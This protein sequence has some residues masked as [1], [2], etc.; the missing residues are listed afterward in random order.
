MLTY[1]PILLYDVNTLIVLRGSTIKKLLFVN[2]L[3]I[4]LTSCTSFFNKGNVEYKPVQYAKNDYRVL[5][6]IFST[7]MTA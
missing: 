3:L 4:I 2:V 1:V 5:K 6:N 7:K